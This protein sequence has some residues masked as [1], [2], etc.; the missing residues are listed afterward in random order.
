MTRRTVRWLFSAA[1][2]VAVFG[3]AGLL[4]L[5][6]VLFFLIGVNGDGP[7]PE[8]LHVPAIVAAILAAAALAF[9]AARWAW[10]TIG[11]RTQ[12]V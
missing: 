1:L 4:H 9:L 5:G 10:T 6:L 3:A 11:S 8:M 7:L 2:F 12:I